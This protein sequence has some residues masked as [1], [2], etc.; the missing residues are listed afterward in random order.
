MATTRRLILGS[1]LVVTLAGVSWA[2]AHFV[3]NPFTGV[4]PVLHR[5]YESVEKG[6]TREEVVRSMG[7][8]AD[9]GVEFRLSQ[10]EGFEK[11]YERAR[12]SNSQ[13]YLFWYSAIDLTYA[14]GF[15]SQDKVMIKACGGT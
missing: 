4:N 15:D 7:Q 9:E 12:R 11:Q 2:F 10:Y 13:Y 8:P 1:T 3:F 6:M 5:R 14:I